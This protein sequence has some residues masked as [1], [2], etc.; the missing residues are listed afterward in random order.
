MTETIEKS[1][2][3]KIDEATLLN[4][5]DHIATVW[6]RIKKEIGDTGWS[7]CDTRV[8]GRSIKVSGWTTDQFWCAAQLF[9]KAGYTNVQIRTTPYYPGPYGDVGSNLRLWVRY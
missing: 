2:K 7:Y 5:R 8:H 9:V 3:P 4:G 1:K 6:D